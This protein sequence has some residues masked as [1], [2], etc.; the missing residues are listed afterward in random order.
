MDFS[1]GGKP[2]ALG[3]G[4]DDPGHEGPVTQLIVKSLFVG[5]VGSLPDLPEV[6]MI[7]GQP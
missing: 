3:A 5:P 4:R 2:E 7:F 1:I 6:R